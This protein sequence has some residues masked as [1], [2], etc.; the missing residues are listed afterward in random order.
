MISCFILGNSV[1][2][3]K[4]ILGLFQIQVCKDGELAVCKG[5]NCSL[6]NVRT[7]FRRIRANI[8]SSQ[9]ITAIIIDHS[10]NGSLNHTILTKFSFQKVNHVIPKFWWHFPHQVFKAKHSHRQQTFDCYLM[11]VFPIVRN[12]FVLPNMSCSSHEH[13]SFHP[14]IAA[15]IILRGQ[16]L[17]I[18]VFLTI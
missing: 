2:A 13:I 17:F 7:D 1:V 12:S 10:A 14:W 6:I 5:A 11:I 15:F 3:I 16:D 9:K 18:F 4:R 8:T